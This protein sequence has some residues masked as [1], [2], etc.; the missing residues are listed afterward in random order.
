MKRNQVTIGQI[1]IGGGAP[2][3][4]QSMLSAHHSDITGN[5]AQARAL[6]AAGCEI[7]RVSV[8]DKEAV[9]LIPAI[10]EAVS[11]PVVADIHFDYMLA[12]E[13]VAAG[14]DKIRINP[15]NI[16]SADRVKAVVAVC[17]EKGIPIRVG[18]NS[19]SVE[20][21][22]LAK[23]G[24]A[25]AEALAESALRNAALIEQCG[26][27]NIVLSLKSSDIRT[28]IKAYRLVHTRC[29]YPLHL[30]V[31]EAGTAHMGRIKSAIGIG[32]LL[33]D[34]IGDTIRVSLTG[35]PVQEIAAAWDILNATGVRRSGVEIIACPTCGRTEVDLSAI[36]AEIERKT[37]HIQVPLKVAVMGC[38]VNGPGEATAADIGIACGKDGALL[39]Q[40]GAVVRK[41]TGNIAQA[42][43]EEI[44]AMATN[45]DKR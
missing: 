21:E 11:M 29:T 10:K 20:R 39:F 2:V 30:G 35:E 3:A 26:Y 44:E 19:G 34:G 41:L 28:M 45:A 5:V 18:V 37:A 4:V 42:L 36:A 6:E 8:P 7:V 15:G 16:G 13:S 22:L 27:D 14:A 23:Y 24:A 17:R 1:T 9:A 40:R 33:C 38:A 12:M 32:S 31:T 25:S 43:L